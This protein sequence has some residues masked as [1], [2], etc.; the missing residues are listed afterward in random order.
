Q[1]V[2]ITYVSKHG[3]PPAAKIEDVN[4]QLS[5]EDVSRDNS[6]PKGL[7]GDYLFQ[8]W[9]YDDNKQAKANDVITKNVTLNALWRYK[10]TFDPDDGDF[11]RSYNDGSL[12]ELP[13]NAP[14]DPSGQNR[15]FDGWYCD[16]ELMEDSTSV[17]K[18][19][20]IVA[21]WKEPVYIV[22]L[23]YNDGTGEKE[24]PFSPIEVLQSAPEIPAK[25]FDPAWLK[26]NLLLPGFSV[27]GW[28]K[29]GTPI[30]SLT[31][32]EDTTLVA[33]LA[34][35]AAHVPDYIKSLTANETV[36]VTGELDGDTLKEIAKAIDKLTFADAA[37]D[38][39]LSGTTGLTAVPKECFQP[40][41]HLKSIRLPS[42]V[43]TI[44]ASAFSAAL[45]LEYIY[46][47]ASVKRIYCNAFKNCTA[48]NKVEFENTTSNWVFNA[49]A[50]ST[51]VNGYFPNHKFDTPNGGITVN[52]SN[53]NVL[54]KISD[55]NGA[56]TPYYIYIN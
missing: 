31:L 53:A 17:E 16:G 28:K 32:T 22:T 12:L 43:E 55:G 9:R 51:N 48:L 44:E 56:D 38:L 27:T 45:E 26:S 10:V 50:T 19:L 40:I 8:G 4:Y 52:N 3:T 33:T 29:D 42:T 13:V 39:D 36:S 18:P 1:R 46:I 54:E 6:K 41:A 35:E 37:I 25:Y 20:T 15:L 49:G 11:S 24:T 47:P 14:E 21:K 34:V 7:S 30:S 5:A 2:T 23:K